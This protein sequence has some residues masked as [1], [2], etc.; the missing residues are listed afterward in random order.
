M[1]KLM[2]S[3]HQRKIKAFSFSRTH[4]IFKREFPWAAELLKQDC[5]TQFTSEAEATD[6]QT[7]RQTDRHPDRQ[8]DTQTDRQT[9][10]KK[11]FV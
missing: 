3:L 1:E 10:K 5:Y 7:D 6:R 4:L 2:S 11:D 8:T 9:D